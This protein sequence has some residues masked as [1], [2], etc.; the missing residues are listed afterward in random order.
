MADVNVL[1]RVLSDGYTKLGQAIAT[2]TNGSGPIAT[3]Q[4]LAAQLAAAN[5]AAPHAGQFIDLYGPLI[6]DFIANTDDLVPNLRAAA[7]KAR[8][9]LPGSVSNVAELPQL[10]DGMQQLQDLIKGRGYEPNDRNIL[11]VFLHRVPWE[12]SDQELE[13]LAQYRLD[14]GPDWLAIG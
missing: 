13:T 3:T 2:S 4:P 8:D 7:T 9:A 14:H 12:L 5:G 1:A 6:R 10:V 11:E